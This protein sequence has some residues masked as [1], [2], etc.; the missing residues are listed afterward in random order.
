MSV[1]Q[2]Y[3]ALLLNALGIKALYVFG[4]SVWQVNHYCQVLEETNMHTAPVQCN[5]IKCI[6]H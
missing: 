3:E 6:Q 1:R 4:N 5:C 2:Q